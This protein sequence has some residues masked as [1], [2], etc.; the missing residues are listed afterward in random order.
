MNPKVDAQSNIM[1]EIVK[2]REG[3]VDY[4]IKDG[5]ITPRPLTDCEKLLKQWGNC[6][7]NGVRIRCDIVPQNGPQWNWDERA[8]FI[9]TV[10]NKTGYFRLEAVT[11][12]LLSVKSKNGT[13]QV[14]RETGSPDVVQLP[15]IRPGGSASTQNPIACWCGGS[16][17]T[18]PRPSFTLL[19]LQVFPGNDTVAAEAY[20][21]YRAVP[22]FEGRCTSEEPIIGT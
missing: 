18:P 2:E 7:K 10:F 5:K 4:S 12:H 20:V 11:V 6:V 13:A 19:C 22:Y 14:T 16:V 17:Y 9:V 1:G 15:D 3:I 8:L 21:T